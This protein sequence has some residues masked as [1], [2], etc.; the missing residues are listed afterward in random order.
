MGKNLSMA[1]PGM[2]DT[3]PDIKTY[4]GR[5]AAEYDQIYLRP[6]RQPAL[7]ALQRRVTAALNGTRILEV[8][9][10][11][12]Y[13]T[14]L[15]APAAR[16]VLATD[17]NQEMLRIART[18]CQPYPEVEFQLMDGY[19]LEATL[20]SFD[21]AFLGFWWSH[22]PKRDISRFLASLHARLEDRARVVIL[23]NLYVAG[24]S[25]P[26][27]RTDVDGNTFQERKLADGSSYEVLK[28]FPD[29]GEISA[30]VSG[31]SGDFIYENHD[32][33]WFAQYEFRK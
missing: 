25:T 33:Y 22:I 14:R 9:C 31:S 13:W 3:S 26:V 23:D 27:S 10:G 24:N 4:Y 12:G 32:F 28:N 16:A 1:D 29:A 18:R 19:N 8:A 30:A 20:G 21:G 15:L 17:I 5:R 7:R 6:E 11:T 2:P